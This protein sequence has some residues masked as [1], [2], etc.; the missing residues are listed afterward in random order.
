MKRNQLKNRTS[1]APRNTYGPKMIRQQAN[2]ALSIVGLT[3]GER[4][5]REGRIVAT[6]K[7]AAGLR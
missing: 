2:P 6:V 4:K 3:P 5:R 1:R 7:R